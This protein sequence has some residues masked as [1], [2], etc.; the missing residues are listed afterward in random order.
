V[1]Q[2]FEEGKTE[3]GM[4]HYAVR[5]YAGWHHH[6]LMTMLA[7]FFLWHLKIHVGKKSPGAH[8][9]PS[10]AAPGSGLTLADVEDCRRPRVTCLATAAQSPRLSVAEKAA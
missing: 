10:A 6:M 4:A 3:L 7:H 5:K 1:E 8:G 9:V 2:G